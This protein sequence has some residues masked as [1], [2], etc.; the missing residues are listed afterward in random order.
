MEVNSATSAGG[1]HAQSR[2]LR[3]EPVPLSVERPTEAVTATKPANRSAANAQRRHRC[4][5]AGAGRRQGHPDAAGRRT[6]YT[7]ADGRPG[8]T[9]IPVTASLRPAHCLDFSGR[10]NKKVSCLGLHCA[11]RCAAQGARGTPVVSRAAGRAGSRR[12]SP[13]VCAPPGRQGR[14]PH[15]G[16][17]LGFTGSLAGRGM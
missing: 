14:P 3:A 8:H 17:S 15:Y 7:V 13:A 4:P 2:C 6:T 9:A 12:G 5:G 10:R 1:I 11:E 16:S